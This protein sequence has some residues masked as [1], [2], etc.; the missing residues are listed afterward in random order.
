MVYFILQ[1][2][3]WISYNIKEQHDLYT[4]N[5]SVSILSL[6]GQRSYTAMGMP[7]CQLDTA[8]LQQVCPLF[9]L[10]RLLQRYR[11]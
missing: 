10:Q 2:I 9:Y 6:I 4:Y 8:V 5:H 1:H 7:G 11:H 3:C